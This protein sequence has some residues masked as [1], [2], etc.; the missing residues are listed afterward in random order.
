MIFKAT[1]GNKDC[2]ANVGHN[3]QF[4]IFTTAIHAGTYKVPTPC[5]LDPG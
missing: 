3:N 4:F 5:D 2:K 1:L